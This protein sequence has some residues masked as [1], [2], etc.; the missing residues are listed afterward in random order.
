MH[1]DP[2]L[3][4][5]AWGNEL[6]E[7]FEYQEVPLFLSSALLP[8]APEVLIDWLRI[9]DVKGVTNCEGTDMLEAS[10]VAFMHPIEL[11]LHVVHLSAG[12]HD[13]DQHCEL[14]N[15][16]RSA[17]HSSSC[18]VNDVPCISTLNFPPKD[19]L[20]HGCDSLEPRFQLVVLENDV[21]ALMSQSA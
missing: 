14:I 3:D 8:L 19:P 5:T 7:R 4:K 1:P 18:L 20:L 13:V 10:R 6:S 2:S 16:H 12:E 9:V 15:I 21:Y 11:Q 17:C